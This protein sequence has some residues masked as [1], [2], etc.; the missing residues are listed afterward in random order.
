MVVVIQEF[1]ECAMGILGRTTTTLCAAS[2]THCWAQILVPF[3]VVVQQF[4]VLCRT[5]RVRNAHPPVADNNNSLCA[6][7]TAATTLTRIVHS[8]QQSIIVHN[9]AAQ[10]MDK[11]SPQKTPPAQCV[12]H[13][14]EVHCNE[15]TN[16]S[17]MELD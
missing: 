16:A 4:F 9:M 1:A 8:T 3:E 2:N 6:I 7:A 11:D 5:L 12:M 13:G 15:L 14:T 10:I 17:I